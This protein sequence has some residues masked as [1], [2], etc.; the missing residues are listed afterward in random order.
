MRYQG[1]V[2]KYRM[3]DRMREADRARLAKTATESAPD[4]AM[5]RPRRARS[6]VLL[7]ALSGLKR[8]RRLARA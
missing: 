1:D 2:A 4:E 5:L 6:G 3:A 8:Y 7:A